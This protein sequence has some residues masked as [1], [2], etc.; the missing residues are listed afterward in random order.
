MPAIDETAL[1][2]CCARILGWTADREV[3]VEQAIRSIEFAA[4][5][6]AALVLLGETDLVPIAHAQYE[7]SYVLLH[8]SD[9]ILLPAL[10]TRKRELPRIVEEYG[11]DARDALS[12]TAPFT[13]QDRDWVI[14]R[15]AP[16]LHD[17]ELATLRLVPVRHVGTVERAAELLRMSHGALGEWFAKAPPSKNYLITPMSVLMGTC[18][19][20]LTSADHV[21]MIEKCY[22]SSEAT[23]EH[24]KR[25]ESFVGDTLPQGLEYANK[26][27]RTKNTARPFGEAE[28]GLGSSLLVIGRAGSGKSTFLAITRKRLAAKSEAGARVLLHIDLEPR[29]QT[30]AEKFDHDR[31]VDEVCT[32]ILIQAETHYTDVNPFANALLREILLARFDDFIRRSHSPV[33]QGT[34]DEESRIDD[35]IQQHIKKPANHLKAYLG[36]LDR[37]NL[38]ATVLLDNVDRGTPEFEKIVFQL[39]QTLARNTNATI[40]TSLR[41]TTYQSG[42]TRGFLDVG[43]HTVLAISPPPFVEVARRRFDYARNRLKSDPRLSKRF[44]RALAGVSSDRV[45]DFADIMSE[46]ILGEGRGIQGRIQ[47]LV[48]TNIRLAL[49]LL[50]D[51]ATSPN[52]DLDK[53]FREYRHGEMRQRHDIGASLDSFLR[54]VMRMKRQRYDES[55]SKIVNLFQVPANILASHF[56][57]VR[58][59]QLLAWKSRQPRE[60]ADILVR[61]LIAQLGALGHTSTSV[62]NSLSHLGEHGLVNSLSR[63]EPPWSSADAVRLGAAGRYYLEELIYNREYIQELTDDLIVYDEPVFD[64]LLHLHKDPSRP[65]HEKYEEKSKV[66][67]IYLARRERDELNRIGPQS[68]RPE[69]LKPVAEEIGTRFFGGL[70]VQGLRTAGNSRRKLTR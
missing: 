50:E 66:M 19:G 54:S 70:F 8:V 58:I 63:P 1:H 41:E 55:G 13:E 31:L 46:M 60:A 47:A 14:A 43:R 62:L 44:D 17:I 10:E 35:L 28:H 51:F 30:H 21:D 16:S 61:D 32:D 49:E 64:S 65:W 23:D 15:G 25:L 4:D 27:E 69:W 37:R 39:A 33:L 5:Y 3:A 42:K 26:L 45:F 57:A 59:L 2:S 56:T 6:S 29:T 18:F 48:G 40:V 36:Y 53:L 34:S 67:L 38:T 68:K 7:M 9:P 20:D 52:T 24:L 11:E 22:V 12:T